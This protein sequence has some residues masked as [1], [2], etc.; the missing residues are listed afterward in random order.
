MPHVHLGFKVDG[1]LLCVGSDDVDA[2]VLQDIFLVTFCSLWTRPM[3]YDAV[4]S[5]ELVRESLL[6]GALWSAKYDGAVADAYLI[7]FE[8]TALCHEVANIVHLLL[9]GVASRF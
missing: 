5:I 1:S 4:H 9:L 3:S 8:V 6:L 2:V 7:S